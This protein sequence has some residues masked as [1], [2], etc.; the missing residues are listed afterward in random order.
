MLGVVTHVIDDVG[1]QSDD[2]TA[3]CVRVGQRNTDQLRGNSPTPERGLD[4]GVREL[5]AITHNS[6]VDDTDDNAIEHRL[7]A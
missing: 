5:D 6:V 7:V 2:L 4:F 3:G 1:T